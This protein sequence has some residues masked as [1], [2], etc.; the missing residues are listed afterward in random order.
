MNL[1]NVDYRQILAE[2]EKI[3]LK[4]YCLTDD[5]MRVAMSERTLGILVEKQKSLIENDFDI[6]QPRIAGM[7]VII[8]N[9]IPYG[10]AKLFVD[11]FAL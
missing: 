1:V 7:K 6:A 5:D 2:M 4:G 10:D 8:D 11:T 3:K 9:S